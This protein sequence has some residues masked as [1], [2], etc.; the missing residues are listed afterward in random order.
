[1]KLPKTPKLSLPICHAL[2]VEGTGGGLGNLGE[3]AIEERS[4]WECKE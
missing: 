1:M 4:H 3:D 2:R